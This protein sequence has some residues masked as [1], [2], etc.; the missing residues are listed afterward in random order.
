MDGTSLERALPTVQNATSLCISGPPLAQK[1][2]LFWSLAMMPMGSAIRRESSAIVLFKFLVF[3][4]FHG[5]PTRS[6]VVFLQGWSWHDC[7][8]EGFSRRAR[9]LIYRL[10]W[11]RTLERD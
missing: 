5:T 7:W 2:P 9:K 6:R 8:Q 1:S 10:G 11:Q 4:E 3:A